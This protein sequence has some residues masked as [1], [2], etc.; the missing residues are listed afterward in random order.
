[1]KTAFIFPGQG[2]QHPGMGKDLATKFPA[3]REVFETAD[4]AL[5][6]AISQLC[7]DGPAEQLHLTDR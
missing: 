2:S 3:A 4:D 5:G 7:F 1:M 6:F